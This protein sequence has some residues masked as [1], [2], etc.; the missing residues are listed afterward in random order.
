MV[1]KLILRCGQCPGDIVMLTAAI[2]DLHLQYPGQFITDAHTPCD[3]LFEN[4]PYITPLDVNDPGA[5]IINMEHTLIH[6]SNEGCYHFIHGFRMWLAQRLLT[7]IPATKMWGDIHL[8]DD[9]KSW[10]GQVEEV[11]G[12]KLPFW[13]INAG[14]KNDY[15]N[16][17]WETQRYQE[18]VDRLPDVTFVQV[19][20]PH[21]NHV[22]ITGDNVIN[23]VG[24]TDLRQFVRLMYWSAGVITPVS[25]AM[26]LAAAVEVH[27]MYKRKRRPVI[28][29]AGGRKPAVWE[30]YTNH[31]YLH[32]CGK[33]PCCDNGGCWKSRVVPL[34]DGDKKDADL[35]VMPT[36]T[37]SG[38]TIPKCMDMITVDEVVRHVREYLQEYD[39]SN[40]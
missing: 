23:L 10:I 18:V 2:R 29:I 21:H 39:Y 40:L 9:E 8:S 5:Q 15:T 19:G 17:A 32:A 27:P 37:P 12:K 7:R 14:Y 1:R 33:L 31:T 25:F 30:A 22:E 16:K 13:M 26:H 35:C 20:E 34:G 4:S 6:N 28:A 3:A 24:K 11:S 38:Q 36:A